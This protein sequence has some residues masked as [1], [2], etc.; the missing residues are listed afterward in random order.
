[1]LRHAPAALLLALVACG[2]DDAAG[3][4]SN[5]PVLTI[6]GG[7]D[8]IGTLGQPL[9]NPLRVEL[10]QGGAPLAGQTVN[11]T[12]A[13]GSLN[14]SSST[15]D[16]V[17]LASTV[18]T[19]PGGSAPA[20][21]TAQATASGASA[22]SFTSYGVPAGAQVIEVRNNFFEPGTLTVARNV[23]VV[24]VWR[25]TSRNHDVDPTQVPTGA[26]WAGQPTVQN[27]PFV[28]GFTFTT[29]GTYR[30]TCSVHSGMTGTITVN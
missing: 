5:T 25:S 8:Q 22:I 24:W 18:W 21:L 19:L 12:N 2:G 1:M 17:G 15:T 6:A 13:Q 4:P 10:R 3:P 27:G 20:V 9:A 29:A 16:A 23:P 14:P 11:W 7:D 30:Y 26:T 28:Y